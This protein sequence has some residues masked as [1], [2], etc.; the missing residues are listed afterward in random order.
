[1]RFSVLKEILII[2]KPPFD[3]A[4]SLPAMKP[5]D[6]SSVKQDVDSLYFLIDNDNAEMLMGLSIE[7]ERFEQAI[8]SINIRNDF[9]VNEVQ[10]ALSYYALNGRP[11]PLA[12]FEEKLG[13]R[14]FQGALNGAAVMYEH[15][16]KSDI[17]LQE[18]YTELRILAKKLFPGEKFVGWVKT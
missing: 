2:I 10:P 3:R 14:L 9:Y 12:E 7:Q 17:S 13:E 6:Y 4:L 5:S 8:S 18:K 1:M 16:Y 11:L 15:V